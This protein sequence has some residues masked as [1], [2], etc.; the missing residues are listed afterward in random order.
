MKHIS[1]RIPQNYR[2]KEVIISSNRQPIYQK[3]IGTDCNGVRLS[4]NTVDDE[5]KIPFGGS[6]KSGGL[7][8]QGA[9]KTEFSEGS[10]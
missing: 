7:K 3:L 6:I 2:I 4:L 8:F 9:M 1:Q 5:K 10:K